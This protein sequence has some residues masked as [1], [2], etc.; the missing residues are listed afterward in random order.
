MLLFLHVAGLFYDRG[1]GADHVRH[2]SGGALCVQLQYRMA[3][4]D[5]L[6]RFSRLV[7]AGRWDQH[8]YDFLFL[9]FL[10]SERETWI[11]AMRTFDF[12]QSRVSW[13]CP[14]IKNSITYYCPSIAQT[15]FFR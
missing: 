11:P 13:P 12:L 6:S 1:I 10:H 2:V 4:S 9:G 7:T 14:S 15:P 5:T 8:L 3:F